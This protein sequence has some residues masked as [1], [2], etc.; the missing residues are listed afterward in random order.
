MEIIIAIASK[1]GES[2]VTPLGRE[3]G[4]SINYHS[5]LES[6]KG[7]IKKLFDKKDGVQGWVDAAQR[8]GENIKPDVQSWLKNVNDMIQKVSHFEDEINKKRRCMY[9]WNLSRKAYK[10]KQD[11]L[12]LQNEGR[13]E[14]VA[15]P[16]PPP[17]IWSTFEKGFKD[18][19]S[20]MANMN[21]VIEGLKR[22][23]VRM[24][25]IC[26]MGGV[27]KT[28]M[29][30]EI[31]TRLA[32]L[33]LFDNIV[34]AT[35]SQSPS[36]RTIQSEIADK[37]G[38]KFDEESEAGRARTLHGRLT[39]IKR[40][41][42]VL[43]D[44]WTELDFKAIGLPYEHTN[45]GCKILL[46]SRNLEVCNEMRSQQIIE[47][48][49]LTTEESEELFR[50]MVGESFDDPDLHS[51]PK[52]V[53]KECG[54]LP[55][56]LVTVGKALEK[57]KKHE[58][59]DALNQLRN[60]NP[61]NIPG[62]DSK[63]YSSI[64]LSYD[65]LESD[66]ARSCL[67]LC[68]LFPEDY[69]IPIEYLIRYGWGRG[70]FSSIVTL[71][72]ARNRVHSLV[73]Q[74]KRRFLLLDGGRS[75]TTK[76][77]DIWPN[78]ATY[79]TISLVGDLE[80]PVGCPKLELL[81]MMDGRFSKG[82]MDII[83]KAM[84]EL[85]VLAL[86]GMEM[87]DLGS[88]R[89]PGIL[90][91]L[92]TMILDGSD[93][94]GMSTDV[95]GPLENLEILSFRGCDSMRELPREIGRLKQLRL[96][97]TTN[98]RNLEVIPH[99]IFSSLCRLE[100]LYMFQKGM[101]SISEV[102]SLSHHLKVLSIQIPSVIH[103]LPKDIV[104]KSPTIKFHIYFGTRAMAFWE[105][106][107][108]HAESDSQAVGLMLKK[109]KKL[110]LRNV[111]NFSALT[112]LDEEGFQD[113]KVLYLDHCPNMEYL[114]NGTS[115]L[116]P[117]IQSVSQFPNS[118]LTNL[119]FLTLSSCGVLKYAFSLSVMRNLVQLEGLAIGG[120][121][122]MEEIVSKQGREHD[123]EADMISF[124]KLTNLNLWYLQSLVA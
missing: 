97:D 99:G 120:C 35:V 79:D 107:D 103:L 11:V 101:A 108:R 89:S 104:L 39:E 21:E 71:E 76:M 109:S 16:A 67:L 80:I 60:S 17:E 23:E 82:S 85:K 64:K 91:N 58:W 50:E 90:K 24:I 7:E 42:I 13:F 37:I 73:D 112:D 3:F 115:A 78:L 119:R 44:V 83:W 55:I 62:V 111:K 26:G 77:H 31:I 18:F 63:V 81:Q 5:N 9:R 25:G 74:L 98:C 87:E 27:G 2:L 105:M 47:V 34:M 86:V 45:K 70:Y 113:L 40:I 68:C 84:K 4:Y 20:R 93:F 65:G 94:D 33:N 96:L 66:E 92:R 38:L 48:G 6:L 53:V 28:T 12:Q 59:E 15:H 106:I 122:Q 72:D 117:C 22:E 116:F 95:I 61:V 100:E 14:N 46:T 56:A 1:I 118:F 29:V 114:V 10:I 8:N 57:K 121:Y 30:K 43:D 52:D 32:K 19:K 49:T 36:I 88:S 69:N 54:G 41:L 75:E 51:T 124:H 123:E 110:A 102:M